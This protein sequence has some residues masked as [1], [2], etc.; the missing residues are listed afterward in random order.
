[1]FFLAIFLNVIANALALPVQPFFVIGV[2]F[3][4]VPRFLIDLFTS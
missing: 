3:P 4:L 1:M 2:H